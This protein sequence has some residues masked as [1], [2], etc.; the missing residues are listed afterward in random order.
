MGHGTDRNRD[1]L[2]SENEYHTA[3]FKKSGA[4]CGFP[5]IL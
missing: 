1:L 2:S 4:V 5:L 3:S